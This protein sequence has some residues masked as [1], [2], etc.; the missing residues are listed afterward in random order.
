M[1][2][3]KVMALG[4]ILTHFLWF[5]RYLNHFNSNCDPWIVVGKGGIW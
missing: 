1:I 4:S 3:S 5:S 2:G